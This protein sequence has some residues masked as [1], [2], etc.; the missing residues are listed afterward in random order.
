MNDN[1][2][3]HRKAVKAGILALTL[4]MV[5]LGVLNFHEQWTSDIRTD[6]VRWTYSKGN[7][8]ADSVSRG[9][10]GETSQIEPGDI[11]R[12]INFKPVLFPQDVGK[13]LR[14]D[15]IAGRPFQ[16]ELVRGGE[17]FVRLLIPQPKTSTFYFYL[18]LVGFVI[19]A[20][21]LYAFLKSRSR[22][23][24]LH[25]Y[26]LCLAFYGAYVFSPTGRLDPLDWIF[27]WGDTVFLLLLPPLFL[28][29]AFYFPGR[30]PWKSRGRVHML[31]VPSLL[32]LCA[33]IAV[34]LFYYYSPKSTLMPTVEGYLAFENVELSYV[35]AGLLAGIIVLFLSYVKSEDI[36]ERKQL[37]L[38]L[39]G[40][41]AG[42]GP[43]SLLWLI[44]LA[45]RVPQQALEAALVPQI[46][47]PLSLT[48][49]LFKYRLMDVDII[50]KRGMIYTLTTMVLFL[51]Y[52]LLTISWV[53]F[54]MPQASLVKTVAVASL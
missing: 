43:F 42:F 47:I 28:H 41:M 35:F 2:G 5:V 6:G 25:F 39:A 16:Y 22:L 33:R 24:A 10:A 4:A 52:L 53:Q 30:T 46:L 34:T 7:L 49:A 38:V 23:F 48:Y 20:I 17:T 21:G 12:S 37:K 50:I 14:D 9:S 13:I 27:F 36:I 15:A 26:F 11:L 19:L 18:S 40:V 54:I 32:L 44:S 45:V 31:Y 8:V 29:F 3:Q 1:L 51:M